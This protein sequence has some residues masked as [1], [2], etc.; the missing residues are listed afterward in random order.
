MVEL[1]ARPDVSMAEIAQQL[2]YSEQSTL[3]RRFKKWLGQSPRDYRREL[4]V[5]RTP[6]PL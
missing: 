1:L 4:N 3:T 2:G 5:I 6:R